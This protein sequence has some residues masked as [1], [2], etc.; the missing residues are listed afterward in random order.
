[1]A[2][3]ISLEQPAVDPEVVGL[4]RQEWRVIQQMYPDSRSHHHKQA[5]ATLQALAAEQGIELED[6]LAEHEGTN[7]Q[8]PAGFA[9]VERLAQPATIDGRQFEGLVIPL[10]KETVYEVPVLECVTDYGKTVHV[11]DLRPFTAE[12]LK[13]DTPG[14][15]ADQ[16]KLDNDFWRDVKAF[17]DNNG[18]AP[19]KRI[20]GRS[21]IFYTKASRTKLRAYWMVVRDDR[22][23]GVPTIA[24]LGD[25]GDEERYQNALYRALFGMHLRKT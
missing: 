1:M 23:R 21:Q 15:Q 10:A 16:D 24:R 13:K 20:V 11:C 3:Q 2:V 25:C 5:L 18:K 7:Q 19:F 14:T 22:H 4:L 9:K 8:L 6:I 12:T 17:A